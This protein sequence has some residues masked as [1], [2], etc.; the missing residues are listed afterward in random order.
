MTAR[1]R[2]L[3][4]WVLFALIGLFAAVLVVYILI[5]VLGA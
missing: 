4:D 2:R 5:A 3:P 1:G